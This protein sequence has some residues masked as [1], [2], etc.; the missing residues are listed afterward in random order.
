MIR[1]PPRSTRTDTLF[2]YTTLFRSDAQVDGGGGILVERPAL[3]LRNGG[4]SGEQR[5]RGKQAQRLAARE[6]AHGATVS[7]A[8][9]SATEL[10]P[11][12]ISNSPGSTTRSLST[13]ERRAG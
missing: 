8:D 7:V 12:M 9:L 3:P 5:G 6:T 2:P 4:R 11:V 1:R 13:E 10:F